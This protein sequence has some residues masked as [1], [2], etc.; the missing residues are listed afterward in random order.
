MKITQFTD[1]SLRLLLYLGRN[2]DR[3]CTVREVADFYEVSAEHLKKI[4]RRLSELGHIQTVRGKNGGLRLAR[5]PADINL[6]R[7]V[8]EEENL[9]LMPC[10]EENCFCPIPDC[11]LRGVIDT[12][13]A[14]FLAVLDKQTLADLA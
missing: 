5:E 8:R 7:L 3:V 14:A 13:L 4:V 11:K 9:Q 1:I 10:W 6:G 2:R 12:A